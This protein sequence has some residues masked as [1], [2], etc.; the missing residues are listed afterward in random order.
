[1]GG[2][3][4]F[5]DSPDTDT[6]LVSVR[7]EQGNAVVFF[8][9]TY[10]S[11]AAMRDGAPPKYVLRTEVMYTRINPDEYPRDKSFDTLPEYHRMASLC[12]AFAFACEQTDARASQV[13]MYAGSM[14]AFHA[15]DIVGFTSGYK[16]VNAFQSVNRYSRSQTLRQA[17]AI[18]RD[19]SVRPRDAQRFGAQRLPLPA[20]VMV[21]ILRR[22]DLATL[23][24]F[25]RAS[26]A[27]REIAFDGRVWRDLLRDVFGPEGSLAALGVGAWAAVDPCSN[28]DLAHELNLTY[29]SEFRRQ[30]CAKL[31]LFLRKTTGFNMRRAVGVL[32]NRVQTVVV[33]PGYA[34]VKM[35]FISGWDAENNTFD[36]QLV[37]LPNACQ[38]AV[39]AYHY[40]TY[41]NMRFGQEVST[42]PI[43][44]R[45]CC[46]VL[47]FR[48]RGISCGR[49][50][51]RSQLC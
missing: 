50:S 17:L 24:S 26:K 22:V 18:Q 15:G 28:Y 1:M 30:S 35:G 41:A 2:E 29:F 32:R 42:L 19:A 5:F 40:R 13:R 36:E 25:S 6:P 51:R 12:R 44:T 3:T 27:F 10:H 47:I 46:F 37:S 48:V 4:L 39:A 14:A 11:S 7:P 9:D 31:L 43:R 34:F 49:T 16:E 38:G 8:H 21:Y 23:M 33:D 20:D 45:L